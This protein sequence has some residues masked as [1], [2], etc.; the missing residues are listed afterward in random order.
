MKKNAKSTE[1]T[2]IQPKYSLISYT[3]LF[4]TDDGNFSL[5]VFHFDT[6][7]YLMP[8]LRSVLSNGP[9]QWLELAVK[10]REAMRQYTLA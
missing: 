5:L 4:D 3:D 2:V 7:R 6:L 9:V 10:H 1:P 8:Y